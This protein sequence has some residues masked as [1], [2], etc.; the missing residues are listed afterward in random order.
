MAKKP[1]R[2]ILTKTVVYKGKHYFPESEQNWPGDIT[3]ELIDKEAAEPVIEITA[4]QDDDDK[5]TGGN[6]GDNGE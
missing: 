5:K 2:I 4:K 6:V 1:K 3:D